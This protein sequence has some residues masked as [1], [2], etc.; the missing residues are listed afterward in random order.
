M[1]KA[2]HIK[3]KQP[4]EV[5]YDPKCLSNICPKGVATHRAKCMHKAEHY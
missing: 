3:E 5:I 2:K 1:S 4:L